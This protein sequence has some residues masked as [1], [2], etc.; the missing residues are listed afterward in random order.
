MATKTAN[1]GREVLG[2]PFVQLSGDNLSSISPLSVLV[3][4]AVSQGLLQRRQEWVLWAYPKTNG[5]IMSEVELGHNR[6][7]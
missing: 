1:I 3:H 2:F 4:S 6:M 7:L 5:R